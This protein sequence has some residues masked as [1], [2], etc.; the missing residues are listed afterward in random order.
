MTRS[1][2]DDATRYARAIERRWSRLWEQPVVL[3]PRDWSRIARWHALG[4]PLEIVEDAML[5]QV[6]RARARSGAPRLSGLAPLVEQAWSV[7]LE[8]RGGAGGTGPGNG[9]DI[10][11]DATGDHRDNK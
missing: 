5:A 3:S 7:I 4:I 9:G 2:I 6:E 1:R 10:K 8:G 11:G